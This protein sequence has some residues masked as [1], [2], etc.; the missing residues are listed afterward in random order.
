MTLLDSRCETLAWM[1]KASE[2]FLGLITNIFNSTK[3]YSDYKRN[4][5]G[6]IF[7]NL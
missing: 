5:V 4:I 3:D 7:S 1:G 6:K 2:E